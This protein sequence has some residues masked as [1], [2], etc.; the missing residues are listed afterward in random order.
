M[1]INETPTLEDV[2]GGLYSGPMLVDQAF[3]FELDPNNLQAT[4]MAQ[5]AGAARFAFN[6]GLEQ[7][8]RRLEAG[9]GTTDAMA[10]HREWNEFKRENARWWTE[11]SKCAPQEALRD[12]DKAMRS[13][14]KSRRA[15]G[16]RKVGFPR[17]KCKGRD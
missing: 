5:H 7:R 9:E 8:K 3:R 13:F 14:F 10:Q 15:A 1:A 11:V 6:W 12:L 17:F 2:V 4:S 16:S